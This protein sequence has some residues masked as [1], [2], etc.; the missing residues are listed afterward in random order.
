MPYGKTKWCSPFDPDEENEAERGCHSS[1]P[2]CKIQ[3][4]LSCGEEGGSMDS[5]STLSES[6]EASGLGKMSSHLKNEDPRGLYEQL[7]TM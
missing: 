3:D 2:G 1:L 4:L 5:R 6:E 7:N